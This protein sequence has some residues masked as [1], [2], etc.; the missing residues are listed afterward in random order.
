M[1]DALQAV[2]HSGSIASAAARPDRAKSAV[3]DIAF[4]Q[5]LRGKYSSKGRTRIEG[6]QHVDILRKVE[7]LYFFSSSV[8]SHPR[9]LTD[10]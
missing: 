7:G 4:T 3:V 2:R 9:Y 6:R 5:Q 1:H 10:V 8:T